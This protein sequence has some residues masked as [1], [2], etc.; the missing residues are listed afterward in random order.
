MYDRYRF[1]EAG[2]IPTGSSHPGNHGQKRPP[3][4]PSGGLGNVLSQLRSLFQ[5]SMETEDL[6]LLGLLV[7]LYMDSKDEDFLIFLAA[8]V[9]SMLQKD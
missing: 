5:G 2:F 9:F 7:L 8:V 1:P 4:G 3:E 6:L